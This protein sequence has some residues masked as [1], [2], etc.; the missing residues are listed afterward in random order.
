MINWTEIIITAMT[1][2]VGGGGLVTIVTLRDKK[3]A[4]VLENIQKLISSN[5]ETNEEWKEIAA[6]RTS[7]CSELKADLEARDNKIDSLYDEIKQLRADLDQANTDVA[8]AR[9]Y[10]CCTVGCPER[11]PPFGASTSSACELP[12][13]KTT[14]NNN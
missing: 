11:E 2:L 12:L 7:R 6:E 1:L 5:S 9:I 4:L 8:V 13:K 14:T 10:K 3:N